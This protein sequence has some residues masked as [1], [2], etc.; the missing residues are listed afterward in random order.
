MYGSRTV[1]GFWLSNCFGKKE[2]MN[3]V[4]A[5]LFGLI[6]GGKLRPF[7]TLRFPLSQAKAA[8]EAI[9]S[10]KTSGKIVLDPAL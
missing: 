3:D 9:L 4:L 10:R 7:S 8:H 2:L 5:E 6:I 1:S